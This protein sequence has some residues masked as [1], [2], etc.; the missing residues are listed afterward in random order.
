M[1]AEALTQLPDQPG[2]RGRDEGE[3]SFV[4]GE[5]VKAINNSRG[6]EISLPGQDQVVGRR[7]EPGQMPRKGFGATI[8]GA[9]CGIE[10]RTG[11]KQGF[12]I[13]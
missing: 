3:L 5:A 12:E 13:N 7:R 6:D 2:Q 11:R 1:E 4:H 10:R 8:L 9:N